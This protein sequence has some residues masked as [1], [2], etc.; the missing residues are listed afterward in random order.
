[1][2]GPFSLTRS[3][4]LTYMLMPPSKEWGLYAMGTYMLLHV[5]FCTHSHIAYT[6]SDG[7]CSS[8]TALFLAYV[9]IKCHHLPCGSQGCG[10]EF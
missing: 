10:N 1:M 6:A 2:V 5:H 4:T 3:N 7:K 8:C 9:E